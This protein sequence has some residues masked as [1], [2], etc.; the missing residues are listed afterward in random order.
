MERVG[1]LASESTFARLG[2]T[3]APNSFYS[4]N[5]LGAALY[6]AGQWQDAVDILAK[7]RSAYMQAA[8]A[9]DL[10]GDAEA[11]W[12]M[13]RQDGRPTDWLFLAMANHQL[14]QQSEAKEWL[15][16]AQEAVKSK[17]IRDPRR[18]WHRLE[19]ELLLDE[20]SKLIGGK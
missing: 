1:A 18:T 3:D 12:L 2:L 19:L 16:R 8:S 20:A 6:R 13:P 15:K 9:A 4:L 7:S 14:G 10:R 5:T 17:R 11:A